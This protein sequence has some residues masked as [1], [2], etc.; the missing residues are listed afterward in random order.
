MWTVEVLEVKFSRKQ[1]D[2]RGNL[3]SPISMNY[4]QHLMWHKLCFSFVGTCRKIT[5]ID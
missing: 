1:K 3:G 5:A 2:R 4:F